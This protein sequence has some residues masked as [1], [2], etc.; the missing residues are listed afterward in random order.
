MLMLMTHDF[1]IFVAII[2]GS[3][4]G[5]LVV[6]GAKMGMSRNGGGRRWSNVSIEEQC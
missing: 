5:H 1:G 4:V 3:G 6:E 2:L